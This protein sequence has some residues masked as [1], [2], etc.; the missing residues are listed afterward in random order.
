MKYVRNLLILPLILLDFTLNTLLGGSPLETVS[1][2]A[3]RVKI[4]A[5]GKLPKRRFFLRFVD[6]LTELFDDNHLL[7]AA[8]GEIGSMGIVDTPE[9]LKERYGRR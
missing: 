7:E 2:R 3:G 8:E 9:Q 4:A 5:G 1:R 6:W